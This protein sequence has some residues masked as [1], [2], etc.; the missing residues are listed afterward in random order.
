MTSVKSKNVV[1]KK[2][3]FLGSVN[4]GILT[5]RIRIVNLRVEITRYKFSQ[6]IFSRN[7]TDQYSRN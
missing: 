6:C 1:A 5:E 4:E 7:E 3:K 2:Y